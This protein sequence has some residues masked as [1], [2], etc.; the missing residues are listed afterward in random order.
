MTIQSL[1]YQQVMLFAQQLPLEAGRLQSLTSS[2]K[3]PLG[4]SVLLL[5]KR[6]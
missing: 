4:D 5:L 3:S 6:T 1:T 2:A